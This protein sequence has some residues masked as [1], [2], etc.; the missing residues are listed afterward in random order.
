MIID[1]LDIRK[2]DDMGQGTNG[3]AKPT[4]TR[5]M[6]ASHSIDLISKNTC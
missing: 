4:I 5:P 3:R 6:P 1:A 2:G